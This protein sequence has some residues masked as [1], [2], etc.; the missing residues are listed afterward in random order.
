MPKRP[1][2]STYARIVGEIAIAWNELERRL[3]RLAFHYFT[4]DYE[5]GGFVLGEMGNATK[6]EFA[7]FLIERFEDDELLKDRALHLVALINRVRENRNI[8]EHALPDTWAGEY[9]GTVFKVDKRGREVPFVAPIDAL[10]ALLKTM[11]DAVPYA[12]WLVQ[13]LVW[14]DSGPEEFMPGGQTFQAGRQVLASI[15]R[16]R[17]PDKIAPLALALDPEDEPPPPP[18][19]RR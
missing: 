16:P 19:S 5:V 13:C 4:V 3:D 11:Q 6:A 12:R 10:K 8:L 15:D 18:S 17:L 14:A 2:R 1:A 9:H 7:K